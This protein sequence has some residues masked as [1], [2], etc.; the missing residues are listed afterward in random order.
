MTKEVEIVSHIVGGLPE[1]EGGVNN[2]F[3]FDYIP[4]EEGIL[5]LA[6]D[7]KNFFLLKDL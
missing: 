4:D 7:R 2:T 1:A 5:I 6:D 3:V